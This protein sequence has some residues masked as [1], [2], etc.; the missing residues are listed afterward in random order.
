MKSCLII[1][2]GLAGLIAAQALQTN[3]FKV[4]IVDKG[5]GVGGRMATRRFDDGRF[6]HGAQFFTVRSAAFRDY[7]NHWLEQ[8]VAQ[9]WS[10]GFPPNNIEDG[11]P[12][13]RGTEGMTTIA[14]YLAQ[15]LTIHT[16]TEVNKIEQNGQHWQATT[17]AGQ[18]FTADSLIMTPPV[19]QS[20]A[21]LAAGQVALPAQEKQAL[22]AVT[23]NPCF[24][25]LLTLEGESQLPPPGGVQ[26]DG[27]PI[28]WIGDNKMKGISERTAVT[29]HAS[30]EFTQTHFEDDRQEVAHQLM[31]AAHQ[32]GWFDK[33]SVREV[34]VQRW[35][36]AQPIH[37]Y[38]ERYLLIKEPLPIA[39]AGDA[40]Q[41]AKVEGAVLS[42]LAAAQELALL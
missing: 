33:D 31:E 28:R 24:A 25:V 19:P 21:L 41:E 20:L 15:D 3:K 18:T 23:Y 17:A 30:P 39:F 22:E 11:H 2:A 4:T 38:P 16:Q 42:G 13:Y 37:F 27:H 36:Y 40:F 32:Q 34:Q 12:R 10:R 9:E 14:K 35:R 1:G 29:I 6:D 5:R 8:G 7:V 26:I